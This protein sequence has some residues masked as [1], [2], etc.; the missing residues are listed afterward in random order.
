MNT[1]RQLCDRCI[2]LDKGRVVFDGEVGAAIDTYMSS[3]KSLAIINDCSGERKPYPIDKKVH[4]DTVTF[5]DKDFPVFHPGEDVRFKLDFT[6]THRI[7]KMAIRVTVHTSDK[8]VVGL[9]TSP[10]TLSSNP[11]NN[12]AVLSIKTDWLAPGKYI[13]KLT[14][15]SVNE[16]GATQLHDVVEDAFAFEIVFHDNENNGMEWNHSWWGHMML[17]NV[18][19]E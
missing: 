10:P 12:S 3:T 9:A 8:T 6:A 13:I 16:Y 2:V 1:I 14:A 19:I 18:V 17:P 5:L 11:G 15:Y 7:D 4:I